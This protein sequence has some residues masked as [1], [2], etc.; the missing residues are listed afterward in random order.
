MMGSV[1]GSDESV[2]QNVLQTDNISDC[3]LPDGFE[4][5]DIVCPESADEVAKDKDAQE[6]THFKRKGK[7]WEWE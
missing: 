7:R 2:F 3:R 6:K 5:T 4:V 1:G